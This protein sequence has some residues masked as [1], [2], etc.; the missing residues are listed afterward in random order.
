MNNCVQQ[1]QPEVRCDHVRAVMNTGA[2]VSVSQAVFD[3]PT[4]S[5]HT[6]TCCFICF[7]IMVMIGEGGSGISDH[8]LVY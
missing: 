8:E 7:I 1:S 3:L 5:F 4:G 6:H 2:K